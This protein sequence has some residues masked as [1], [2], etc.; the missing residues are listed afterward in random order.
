M[1]SGR[2]IFSG[3]FLLNTAG[4]LG[5]DDASLFFRNYFN[6]TSIFPGVRGSL[7]DFGGVMTTAN[8]LYNMEVDTHKVHNL[9]F[10]GQRYYC[11]PEIDYF[12][13]ASTSTAATIIR[14]RCITIN[15]APPPIPTTFTTKTVPSMKKTAPPRSRF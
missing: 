10:R 8:F 1:L 15:P 9:N 2:R 7:P 6:L 14:K 5:N 11:L 4:G 3:V 12:G 13:R